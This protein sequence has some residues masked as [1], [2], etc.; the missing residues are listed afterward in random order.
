[1][2]GADG[3]GV[4]CWLM[5]EYSLVVARPGRPLKK[6][7]GLRAAQIRELGVAESRRIRDMHSIRLLDLTNLITLSP[8][9]H[10]LNGLPW[11]IGIAAGSFR[12][13]GTKILVLAK[14]NRR[15]PPCEDAIAGDDQH[16]ASKR[17]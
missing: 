15:D 10:F 3:I 14:R 6:S 16:A 11:L 1:M 17:R 7:F 9:K 4:G 5:L 2:D 12:P 8:S 13:D